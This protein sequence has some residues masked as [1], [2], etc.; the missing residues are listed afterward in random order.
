M[1]HESDQIVDNWL[2]VRQRIESARNRYGI[3]TEVSL[4]AVSKTKPAWMVEALYRE[5][6]RDFG[7]NYLQDAEEKI[8][9]LE[10]LDDIRWHFIGQIQ[11]NKTATIAR[12]F[13]WVHSVD[14][15]KIARRLSEQRPDDLPP[16]SLCLQVNLDGEQQKGGV[17]PEVLAELAEQIQ[18]LP[19]V[20]LR[21]LMA[22]PMPRQ[23]ES[24]QR[25]SFAR[26]RQLLDDLKKHAPAPHTLDTLSMGMSGDLEP[27]IAEGSTLVR[28]GSDIFG[29]RT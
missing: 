18:G 1:S 17:E 27:A 15:F 10:H 5:G 28:I 26:L 22:I 13:D 14:R 2:T 16:L 12:L 19:N 11:S 7:E 21:G 29:A 25:N 8:A 6:Q 9:A 24:E 3:A 23:D 4:L 20:E